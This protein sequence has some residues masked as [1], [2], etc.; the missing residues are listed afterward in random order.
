MPRLPALPRRSAQG[1]LR[2]LVAALLCA[3]GAIAAAHLPPSEQIQALEAAQATHPDDPELLL[4]RSAI[5]RRA[6]HPKAA[7]TAARRALRLGATPSRAHLALA[8]ALLDAGDA[9]QALETLETALDQAPGDPALTRARGQARRARGDFAGAARDLAAALDLTAQPSPDDILE[10]M[11]VHV[12]SGDEKGALA[13]ADRVRVRLGAVASIEL[14]AIRLE[15]ESG[16]HAAALARLDRLIAQSPRHTG[17]LAHRAAILDTLD[18][19]GEAARSREHALAVLRLHPRSR[20]PERIAT[21]ERE[22]DAS[23]AASSTPKGDS[24]P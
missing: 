6:G 5:E 2:H 17:W 15:R 16:R 1:R 3:H 19:G 9:D 8:A 20:H 23:L 12:A 11:S 7:A 21:L 18:R 4:Q 24:A 10:A 13:V 14:A 22:I